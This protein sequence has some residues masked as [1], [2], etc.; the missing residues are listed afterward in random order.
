M[1]RRFSVLRGFIPATSS[2]NVAPSRNG[3]RRE[4]PDSRARAG[5]PR[6]KGRDEMI[7]KIAPIAASLAAVALF[8]GPA[9]TQE[10]TNLVD[11]ETDWSIFVEDDP[12][13]CWGVAP[14][15]E[16]VNTRG[17]QQVSVSRGR[18]APDG[19]LYFSRPER[20]T[21]RS[22]RTGLERLNSF[23]E[24]GGRCYL[25]ISVG[26]HDHRD[27]HHRSSVSWAKFGTDTT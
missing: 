10:S 15:K 13:S 5:R 22:F 1:N 20:R 21:D 26:G 12:T 19:E 23:V 16:Q 8:S 24:T 27:A 14:P 6:G 7:L 11:T 9:W 25:V 4:D 2:A 17:G 3:L 18:D